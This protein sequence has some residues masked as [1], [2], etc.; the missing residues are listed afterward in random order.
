MCKLI[1]VFIFPLVKELYMAENLPYYK[2]TLRQLS[3][4]VV[5]IS[6]KQLA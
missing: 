6:M 3:S 2:M 5:S 1:D 4:I